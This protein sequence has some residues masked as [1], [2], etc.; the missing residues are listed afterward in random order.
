MEERV[1]HFADIDTRRTMGLP[2]RKLPPS[3]LVIKPG[4][5][6]YYAGWPFTIVDIDLGQRVSVSACPLGYVIWKHG[7]RYYEYWRS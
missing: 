1:A 2:P 7:P 3:D 5:D 6:Q 4:V